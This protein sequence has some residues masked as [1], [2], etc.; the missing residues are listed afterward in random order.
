MQQKENCLRLLGR[1]ADADAA[2][3]AG[4]FP[5]RPSSF[6]PKL[7]DLSEHYNASLYDGTGWASRAE[8]NLAN[9]PG[10]FVP[11][12]G[13][14]F[15]LRGIVHLDGLVS[16]T[17]R[18]FSERAGESL[19]LKIEGIKVGQQS[20][21]VHF[22]M[23]SSYGREAKGVEVAKF[24]MH[25]SDGTS[26]TMPVKFVDHI[27]DWWASSSDNVETSQIGWRGSHV[28]SDVIL[29]ELVW[30]NPNPEKV[31]SHID[32]ISTNANA[33]PFL[34]AISLE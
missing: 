24:V 26:E 32:F 33:A 11:L 27:A 18:P 15:D 10:T 21:G 25:F 14:E 20:P 19:P 7:I 31:I 4:R 17:G 1:K 22:L 13:V 29:S 9:L 12:K 28:A 30:K 5:P 6:N 8:Y 16:P 3:Q 2:R 34:V 23:S